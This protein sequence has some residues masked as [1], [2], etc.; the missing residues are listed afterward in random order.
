VDKGRRKRGG[1][2]GEVRGGWGNI[3]SGIMGFV[4][5]LNP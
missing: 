3:V 2:W 5:V 4:V 1:V